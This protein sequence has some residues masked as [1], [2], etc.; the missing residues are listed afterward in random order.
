MI[1]KLQSVRGRFY[2]NKFT[3]FYDIVRKIDDSDEIE[4]I[5]NNGKILTVRAS[6][7][8]FSLTCLPK[9]EFP[10]I[11]QSNE[12]NIIKINS[13]VLYRLIEK[14]IRY[15]QRRNKIFFEWPLF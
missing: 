4:V 1:N 5:S 11:D 14:Q 2:N 15:F 3:N 8:R 13:Q 10:I 9:E 12:G 7:S 6:G